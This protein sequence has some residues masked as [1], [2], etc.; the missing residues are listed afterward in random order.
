MSHLHY[1]YRDIDPETIEK[2]PTAKKNKARTNLIKKYLLKSY[3][4][5]Y[6][7]Q[8]E[9]K[10]IFL[11]KNSYKLF[12]MSIGFSLFF[13]VICYKFLFSGIYE[14]GRFYFDPKNIPFAFKIIFTTYL[15]YKLLDNLWSHYI[16]IP[17]LYELTIDDINRNL[18]LKE[19]L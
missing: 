8:S 7:S 17:E 1:Y 19:S 6:E 11:L 16:C 13:N 12:K 15:S 5:N 4:N 3:Y 18:K 10:N 14:Y 9:M 2:L